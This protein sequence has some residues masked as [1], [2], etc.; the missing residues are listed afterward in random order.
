MNLDKIKRLEAHGWKV[1]NAEEFLE[2]TNEEI[3]EAMNRM[4]LN[5]VTNTGYLENITTQTIKYK[6]FIAAIEVDVETEMLYGRVLYIK[7]VVTFQAETV[8]QAKIE[9]TNSVE[10][11]LEFCN[12]V[13]N[14]E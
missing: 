4:I 7:D 9:F 6:D 14:N 3:A 12:D 2:L 10:D 8:K 1:G 5:K 13:R 11:Y